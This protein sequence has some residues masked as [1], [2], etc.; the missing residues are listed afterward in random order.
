[1]KAFT[2][3]L[4]RERTIAGARARELRLAVEEFNA[5]Y[6]AVLD[7]GSV[8]DWPEFFTE[9]GIYRVTARENAELRMPVGLVYAHGR[10][11]MHDRAVA[12]ARTQMFA[13]RYNLHLVTNTRVTAE[14]E[15]G[16]IQAQA[17]FVLLQTLVEGPSTVHMA[18]SYY[19]TFVQVD[20][21]LLLKERQA[22]YDSTIIA[23]DVVYPL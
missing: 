23:N 22:I 12:I 10:N 13:P 20:G 17:N 19:D 16:E 11:M 6:C 4:F 18:G 2:Q 9:D 21:R 14:S 5:D 8:E 1:M 15:A 3:S 7:T